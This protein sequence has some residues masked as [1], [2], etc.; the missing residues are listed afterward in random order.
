MRLGEGPHLCFVHDQPLLLVPRLIL[1]PLF[2]VG[3][4]VAGEFKFWRLLLF[5]TRLT[6]PQSRGMAVRQSTIALFGALL[7]CA[8]AETHL[9]HISS[10]PSVL[11]RAEEIP[12]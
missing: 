7:Q 5:G 6:R 11:S 10:K 1:S 8:A 9:W 2:S 12:S 4:L 3:G